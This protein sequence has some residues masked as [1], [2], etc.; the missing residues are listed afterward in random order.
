MEYKTPH[1]KTVNNATV[2]YYPK[3]PWIA[4]ATV[5]FRQGSKI[6]YSFVLRD[7][8]AAREYF[9]RPG[10]EDMQVRYFTHGRT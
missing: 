4:K 8:E 9:Q 1:G 10:M 7:L 5:N 6:I 3:S 2:H